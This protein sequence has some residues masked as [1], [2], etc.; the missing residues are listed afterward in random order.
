M[1]VPVAVALLPP[2]AW[3][4]AKVLPEIESVARIL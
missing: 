3:F 4:W 2:M 1:S